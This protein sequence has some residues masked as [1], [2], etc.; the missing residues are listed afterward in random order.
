MLF[1]LASHLHQEWIG[2]WFLPGLEPWILEVLWNSQG[3]L[4]EKVAIFR[5]EGAGSCMKVA[6][7]AGTEG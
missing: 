2:A 7:V 1:V 3:L 4:L 5:N 6:Q